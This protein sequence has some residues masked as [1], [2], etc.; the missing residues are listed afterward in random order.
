MKKEWNIEKIQEYLINEK[1]N[2]KIISKEYKNFESPLI[3]ICG[4]CGN[5]F[6][7][8][9]DCLIQQKYK[10]C[11]DC[12]M[13]MRGKNRRALNG[14]INEIYNLFK[15]NGLTLL[16]KEYS[17][18][19][20]RMLCEDIFGYRGF[21]SL[22][23][24]KRIKNS[25]RT[26]FDYF[27][28]KYNKDNFIY[29]I[30]N[31]CLLNNIK[32]KPI[33]ILNDGKYS[34]PSILFLCECGNYFETSISSFRYGKQKCDNC[35]K[36]LSKYENKI[37]K[38]LNENNIKYEKEK[39]FKDCRNILPLP[40]DFYLKHKNILIE[41]DGEG[42]YFPCYFNNCSKKQAEKSYELIKINDNIKNNYC[43]KN[44]IELIRIPYW[45]FDNNN[46][47]NILLNKIINA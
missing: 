42:H 7:R 24:L 43:K 44:N 31:F 26:G 15:E 6:Q 17:N 45:E 16:E 3:F 39:R 46:Y 25:K 2:T 32:S 35:S 1:T 30:N 22:N 18:N 20:R 11:K 41:V 29:N 13:K 37:I 4:K 12:S 33:K 14:N 10:F 23:H 28:I 19:N 5:I 38:F 9:L 47:E 27:S 40:F 8:N 21:V 34:R 36:I